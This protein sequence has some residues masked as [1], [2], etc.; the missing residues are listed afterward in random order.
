MLK[1]T[2]IIAAL[3]LC[4]LASI[5]NAQTYTGLTWGLDRTSDPYK[6]GINLNGTWYNFGQITSA[7]APTPYF[8]GSLQFTATD[9]AWTT[10]WGISNPAKFSVGNAYATNEEFGQGTVP[11]VNAITGVVNAPSSAYLGFGLFTGVSGYALAGDNANSPVGIFGFGGRTGPGTTNYPGA[12]GFNTVTCN[13]SNTGNTHSDAVDHVQLYGGEIDVN[14]YSAGL[15]SIGVEGLYITGGGNWVPI[16]SNLA[17]GLDIDVLSVVGNIPWNE[18]LYTRDGAA[19]VA[20]LSIGTT[21]VGNNVGSQSLSFRSRTSGAVNRISSIYTDASGN[22][23]FSPSSGQLVALQDGAGGTVV[24]TSTGVATIHVAPTLSTLTGYVK[25][26]G[27]SPSTASATV[28]LAD[29]ATQAAT[30]FVANATG[31]VAAPTAV[32]APTA[33]SMLNAVVGDSGAGGTKGLV[34]APAAGD[35][36]ASKFLKADGTWAAVGG[37]TGTVTSVAQSF[38]GG[39][40]SV[41]GSPITTSGTLA[42]TVAGTSGGIPYFSSASAWAS[43][44][45]LAANQIVLGGGAGV[46]PATLGSLGTTTTVLH[47]NAAGAPTF[48][49]VSLSA[50]VTGDLPFANLTQGAT[51]T[52]LANATSG[53]ADFAA[54]A[55]PSCDTATKALQWTTNTGFVC[56]SSINAATLGGA[57]FAAPGTIGGG[58]PGAATFTT[59]A[60]SS[61]AFGGCSIGGDI[62]CTSGTLHITTATQYTGFIFDNGT[63]Q[64]VTFNGLSATNDNGTLSL[65]SGGVTKVFFTADSGLPNYLNNGNN[66]CIGATTC[67]NPLSV[68]GAASVTTHVLNTSGVPAASTCGTTPAVTAN[69]SNAAGQFTTGTGTPAACTITFANAYPTAAFCTVSPANAAAVGT[70]V[71]VSAQSASAFTIT[72]GAGTDSA[73]YQYVCGGK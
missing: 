5:S 38:T 4:A 6:I 22:L 23:I 72:L 40:I 1:T 64:V 66:V 45:A 10:Q 58:T 37:G 19:S 17:R 57:T 18:A 65:L 16:P 15:N 33:T 59:L 31:G 8:S 32:S 62:V 21:G 9:P 7:G 13:C 29:L 63:N 71:Y 51:N 69:S 49:A 67:S 42:L 2:R 35:A 28:P 60:A 11:V 26:A 61:G 68:T 52:V 36:A 27:A 25:A 14:V 73:K 43:S 24:S 34:P 41:G 47:G 56:N 50:D 48:A 20:G 39:L 53:T 46:A 70:S 55:M 54:F 3:I 44:A 30:T 12:W